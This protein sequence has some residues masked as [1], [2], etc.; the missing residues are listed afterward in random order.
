MTGLTP[1]ALDRLETLAQSATQGEWFLG[2]GWVYTQPDNE[3][4]PLDHVLRTLPYRDPVK[5]EHDHA[6]VQRNAEYIAAA[7][8]GTILALIAEVRRLQHW[9]TEALPVVDGLQELGKALGITLGTR[10]TG[11]LA[12]EAAERLN[13]EVRHLRECLTATEHELAVEQLHANLAEGEACDVCS[14]LEMELSAQSYAN[15]AAEND[16][17]RATI[18]RVRGIAKHNDGLSYVNP[19]ATILKILDGG[20]S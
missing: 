6:R 8:P 5:R 3:L 4:D 12:V 19:S 17:L 11:P 1:E 10:I 15:L 18:Q 16:D 7:D 9:R 14:H 13:T 2:D 20:A